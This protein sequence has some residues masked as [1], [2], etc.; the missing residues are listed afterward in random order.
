[1]YGSAI[2]KVNYIRPPI[3][4]IKEPT[5]ESIKKSFNVRAKLIPPQCVERRSSALF[6]IYFRT[7]VR[8]NAS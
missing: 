1:M 5:K 8:L 7:K 4:E 6:V 2:C 3:F